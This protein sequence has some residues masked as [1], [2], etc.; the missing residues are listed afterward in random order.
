MKINYLTNSFII[1]AL[2]TIIAIISGCNN[3]EK[4][5]KTDMDTTEMKAIDIADLDTSVLPAE[6]FYQYATGG[7]QKNN[8]LPA[9]ESRFGSFDLLAKETN[10]KVK[11]L[12]QNLAS[13]EHEKGSVEWKIGTFYNLGLDSVKIEQQG[14]EPL[15]KDFERIKQIET[16]DDIV[17][18]IAYNQRN[19][20]SAPFYLYGSSDKDDAS[21]EIAYI[22]QGGLGL[23]DRDYYVMDDSRSKEIRKE[24]KNHI[25]KMFLLL[26]DNEYNAKDNADIIMKMETQMAKSSM[27]RMEL[28]DPHKTKNKLNLKTINENT[29]N[30]NMALYFELVG[31][32]VPGIIN[33]SQPEFIETLDNMFGTYTINNWKTY[34]RW[35]LINSTAS[36][37]SSDFVNANFDF[38]VKFLTGAEEQKPRWRRV[39]NATNKSLGEA[40][41]QMF[42][43]EYFPPEAKKRMDELVINLKLAFEERI[44]NLDWMSDTTK[45][46]AIEKLHAMNVKIGYPDKWRDYSGLEITENSYV[47]N[48]MASNRFDFDYMI[49][50]IGKKVD[51]EEWFMNPQTVNAYYSP[52]MNEICFPAGILQPPFFYMNADDAVNYGAIGVVIGHEMTHGFDDQGRHY[53]KDGNLAQWWTDEDAERFN[54]KTKVL[55]DRFNEIIVLDTVH[56]NGELSLGENIADFGGLVISYDAMQKAMDGKKVEKID[57]FTPEQRFYLAYA[58]VWAQNIR[59]KEIL[60]RTK[61]DVHSLGKWRVNGQLPGLNSFHKAFNVKED[62]PM[63]LVPEKWATVW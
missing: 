51:K 60:R 63:Y 4:N 8:P 37:L 19:G 35:K 30:I 12:I 38:Y 42:V 41:G 59:D 50:K 36:Y 9:E 49:S 2:I 31:L 1:V 18:Q 23:P 57:G 46:K 62:D 27:T 10:I 53:D 16:E 29:P 14:I 25:E 45:Q 58:K 20:I 52:N 15:N 47:E 54:E 40:V 3:S 33:L 21:M 6:D 39:L 61:E 44:L 22:Y 56:A 32:P 48:V 13:S 7:W 17:S 28:R 43:K 5:N 55:V 34:F 11:E 26:G 24:Y